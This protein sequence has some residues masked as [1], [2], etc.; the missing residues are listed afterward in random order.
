MAISA[1]CTAVAFSDNLW[2][3]D[4]PEGFN[5]VYGF[6]SI[7]RC[8]K[9]C[10]PLSKPRFEHENVQAKIDEAKVIAWLHRN[11]GDNIP[12]AAVEKKE[13]ELGIE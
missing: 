1:C 8:G 6:A 12:F 7:D 13:Q 4:A 9:C 5:G 3:D 10:K 11:R 2:L